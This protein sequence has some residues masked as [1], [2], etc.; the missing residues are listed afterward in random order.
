MSDHC[1]TNVEVW[2]TLEHGG[3]VGKYN[4]RSVV[5]M[6]IPCSDVVG[7]VGGRPFNFGGGGGE[8]DTALWLDPPQQ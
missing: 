2:T 7:T 6:C 8:G 5:L 1:L 4:V 3:G